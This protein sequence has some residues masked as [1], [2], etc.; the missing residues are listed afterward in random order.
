MG[1]LN[2]HC[3]YA[4]RWPSDSRGSGEE[5]GRLRLLGGVSDRSDWDA[6]G[7]REDCDV[8]KVACGLQPH[9]RVGRWSL[10]TAGGPDQGPHPPPEL[11]SLPFEVRIT[12]ATG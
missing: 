6:G 10:L 4:C 1:G 12:A 8:P 3:C 5:D 11:L 7:S 2:S 9:D